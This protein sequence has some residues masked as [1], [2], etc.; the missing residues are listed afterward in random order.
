M[1]RLVVAIAHLFLAATAS[2]APETHQ[3]KLNGHTFTLPKGFTIELAAKTP[4]VD[5]PIVAAFDDRGR[6]YVADSSG[7]N[8]KPDVQLKNPTHRIV[9]L[10][11]TKGT[12]V[13]DKATVFADKMMFPE[14]ILWHRGSVFVGAPPHIWKLTDTDDD[15]KA[16]KR[17]VW[18]DGKTLTGCAN[19]LHGPYLGPDGWIY[20]TKGAFAKQEYTLPNGKK[21]TTRAAHIFRARPDGTGI[22][23]VM[24]GGMDNPVD[25]AF[26]PNGE[27]FFTTTFFQHPAAGQ[28]DGII[29]AIYGGI[30]GKD[31]D[32]IYD[33]DHKWTSP[34]TMPVMTHLGPAAPCGLHCYESGAFGAEYRSNLF[35]CQFNLRKVSRHVLKPHGSTYTT[36]DSD[37]VVSDNQDFHPTDVIEDA[38]GSLLIVDTGGWYKLCCPSSQLVK[39]DVLGAIYRV[40]RDGVKT[41][42]DPGGRK[43]RFGESTISE[44]VGFLGDPRPVVRRRSI[45]E[46]AGRGSK[47]VVALHDLSHH[48]PSAQV[49]LSAAWTLSRI[50]ETLPP[51]SGDRTSIEVMFNLARYD[52]D[53]AVRQATLSSISLRRDPSMTPSLIPGDSEPRAVAEAIGRSGK[54]D[55]ID[56]LFEAVEESSDVIFQHAVTY[57]LIELGDAKSTRARL[58]D[59]SPVVRRCALTALDQLGEKLD[60]KVVVDALKSKDAGLKETAAW[61]LSRHPEWADELVALVRHS[62]INMK[63]ADTV[64]PIARFAKA[65]AVQKL[66]ADMATDRNLD[67]V[68]RVRAL[69]TMGVAN[70][71]ETPEPWAKA[72]AHVMNGTSDWPELERLRVICE[73]VPVLRALPTPKTHVQELARGLERVISDEDL[74]PAHWEAM[75]VM[76]GGMKTIRDQ[77]FKDLLKAIEDNLGSPYWQRPAEIAAQDRKRASLAIE[78]L[79]KARLTPDQL[80]ALIAVLPK[81]GPLELDRTLTAFAQTKDEAIGF[82]LVAAL[83]TPEL[84]PSLR[85]DGVKERIKHFP[86]TVHKAAEKLYAALN[87]EYEQQR[88]KLDEMSKALTAGDIRRGQAV[89]NSVKTSCIACHT[90][91]YVGGKIGPDL[92]RIGGI[93]T[94]RDLLE[95]ILFPS[96]NFVRSY[97]PLTVILKDGRSF[98]GAPKKNAPDEVILVLAADKEQRIVREDIDEVRPG[99]VSIMPAGL[100]KQITQQELADLIAFLRACK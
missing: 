52:N 9:R 63:V 51:E 27:R 50:L 7:S 48:D 80:N 3:V 41:V 65:P 97:E 17:D 28:R 34:T 30:Y 39:E 69:K 18:F 37:F 83:D 36:E 81:V 98:T 87:A 20:W 5:R 11:D 59:A 72:I 24:T 90:I 42:E 68:F 53:A 22:E 40:R 29:H 92:T 32:V 61:I 57:A 47:A 66:L 44:L 15:G 58:G 16:D 71:K 77:H 86:M 33:K 38:D 100:D 2:A 93:R 43:I 8:E 54:R 67:F 89:F 26:L 64:E 1:T 31:H 76:P 82:K 55:A 70:V 21:F 45:D 6:L 94:E 91:G 4:L 84:R 46:L 19:D 99:K 85:V 14:G 73:A 35:C 74:R 95:A 62:L 60:P 78:I 75:A 25:V 88:T 12:G 10:E 56:D 96:A 79:S 49:R 23:P 13:F